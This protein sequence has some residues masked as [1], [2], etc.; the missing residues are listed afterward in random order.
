MSYLVGLYTGTTQ[1]Y[2][3][4]FNEYTSNYGTSGVV[5]DANG[6]VYGV[7]SGSVSDF[8]TFFNSHFNTSSTILLP[9]EW[10]TP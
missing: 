9:K 10:L 2:E 7:E 6:N 5:Y 3:S 8:Q 1:S 4:Y